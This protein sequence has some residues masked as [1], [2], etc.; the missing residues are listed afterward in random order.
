MPHINEA[1]TDLA[2]VNTLCPQSED[3]LPIFIENQRN[4]PIQINRGII[5]YAICDINY[6]KVQYQK[7]C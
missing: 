2:F 3:F 4:Q 6:T 1:N 7:R 5:G